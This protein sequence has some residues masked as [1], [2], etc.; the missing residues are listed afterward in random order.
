LIQ[1][2]KNSSVHFSERKLHLFL[3]AMPEG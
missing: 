1:W 3:R 2:I